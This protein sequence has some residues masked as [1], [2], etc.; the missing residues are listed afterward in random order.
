MCIVCPDVLSMVGETS[1]GIQV[2]FIES[3]K[4]L[5]I[6]IYLFAFELK[7]LHLSS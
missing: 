3:D 1:E 5:N 6:F 7:S 2:V 4:V